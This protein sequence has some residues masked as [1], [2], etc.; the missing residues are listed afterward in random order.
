MAIPLVDP[1]GDVVATF[2]VAT[3]RGAL[4]GEL[5]RTYGV[6]L[7]AGLLS[8]ALVGAVELKS[9][10]NKG[11]LFTIVIPTGEEAL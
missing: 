9:A 5:N 4:V 2:T 10:V 11:S 7:L 6:F 3:D 8:L 1:S